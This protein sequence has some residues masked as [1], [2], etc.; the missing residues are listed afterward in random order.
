MEIFINLMHSALQFLRRAGAAQTLLATAIVLNSACV[1]VYNARGDSADGLDPMA[2]L[3]LAAAGTPVGGGEASPE[4]DTLIVSTDGLVQLRIPAGAMHSTEQFSITRYTPQSDSLPA[5]FIPTTPIYQIT[6]AYRFNRDVEV[7]L[8][9]DEEQIRALNLQKD[10]T[11]GFSI[12][13]TDPA[14]DAGRLSGQG[15]DGRETTVQGDRLIV[16]TRT[17]SL[18]GGGTPPPGNSA[19]VV[20]GSYYHLKP[21]CSYLPWR[22]R[23]QALDPDGDAMQVYLLAAGA[24]GSPNAI[25]MTPDGA[26]WYRADIPYE[27]MQI[28]GMRLKVYAVDAAGHV[29]ERPTF[30]LFEYPAAANNPVFSVGYNPDQDSDGYLDAWEVDNGFDPQSAASPAAAAFPD[31]DGDGLPN[32]ADHTPNGEANPVIDTLAI[33]PSI[34]ALDIGESIVFSVRASL[35]GQPRFVNASFSANGNSIG[36]LPVGAVSGSAFTAAQP[37]TSN[38]TAQVGAVQANASVTVSDGLDPGAITTLTATVMSH[39]QV[40]LRWNATGS[41]GAFG[42]ASAYEVR[43]AMAPVTND[44]EC[45]GGIAIAHALTPKSAG[46]PEQLDIY[47]HSP[48]GTFYYCVRAYDARGNRSSWSGAVSATTPAGPDLI[49]PASVIDLNATSVGSDRVNLNWTAVGDDGNTGAAASYEIRRSASPINSDDDCSAATLT[50][51]WIAS[52]PAGTALGFTVSGLSDS[53]VY[54]F[55]VRAVDDVGN[56]GLWNGSVSATTALAN[57]SPNVS[58]SASTPAMVGAPIT[59]NGGTSFDPDAIAC[60]ANTGAYAIQWTLLGK[61]AASALTTA[62]LTNGNTLTAQFTPD[63][64]GQYSFA[65]EF[66]DDPGVCDGGARLSNVNLTVDVRDADTTAPAEVVWI[67]ANTAATDSFTLD[68][69]TVGD[70][71]VSGAAAYYEIRYSL[72]PITNAAQCDAAPVVIVPGVNFVPAGTVVSYALTGLN[73]K[74]TYYYCI[75]AVDDVGLTGPWTQTRSRQTLEGQ[76]GWGPWSAYGGCSRR[77]G[78]AGVRTRT[79]VC[80]DP[81]LGCAGANVDTAVCDAAER[82]PCSLTTASCSSWGQS[83]SC[84]CPA[85][86]E[87]YGEFCWGGSYRV[88]GYDYWGDFFACGIIRRGRHYYTVPTV[89]ATGRYTQTATCNFAFSVPNY[90]YRC[91]FHTALTRNWTTA[92]CREREMW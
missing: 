87:V 8:Q 25:P 35:A 13:T 79:R 82:R 36:G 74:T 26:G 90:G 80:V 72:A 12:S 42:Q 88:D 81:A 7:T 16:R 92:L 64:V 2:L 45:T 39:T 27:A 14:D 43:R 11:V 58:A 60:G 50:P 83:V 34:A 5:G 76:A 10:R 68:W 44:A 86:Y 66:T 84:S 29:G 59:L 46:L 55:C 40:R 47:G 62:S 41:D 21:N 57:R 48:G 6:P 28:G 89:S 73:Q 33:F 78:Y 75:R 22:V 1:G 69:Q 63:A 51:N 17:F 77:C 67:S 15:W 19:P 85:N 52:A 32:V 9:L 53:Q 24:S 70:D 20:T 3:G 49:G 91:V 65:L 56:V 61:P 18:F 23:A 30:G 38:V 37:G 4:G 31:A 71:G 54:Y